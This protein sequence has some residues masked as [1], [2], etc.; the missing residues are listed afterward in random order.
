MLPFSEFASSRGSFP[1]PQVPP[2]QSGN[3]VTVNFDIAWLPF[4]LGSLQQL[5]LQSTWQ[6]D[7]DAIESTQS[8]VF[9]LISQ[10]SQ[11]SDMQPILNLRVSPTNPCELQIT[12]DNSVWLDVADISG[13]AAQAVN[14]YNTTLVNSGQTGGVYGHAPDI[15]SSPSDALRCAVATAC[16]TYLQKKVTSSLTFIKAGFELGKAASDICGDLIEAIPVFGALIKATLDMITGVDTGH[17]D[18]L[19]GWNADPDQQQNWVF[20][21]LYCRLGQDGVLT[22]E[23]FN[24]WKDDLEKELPQGGLLTLIG[25]YQGAC[26]AALGFNL[27]RSEAFIHQNDSGTACEPCSDCPD[28]WCH[29]FDFLVSDCGFVPYANGAV[30]GEGKWN[31]VH[32]EPLGAT[33]VQIQVTTPNMHI[34]RVQTVGF[35]STV[36]DL[37]DSGVT[38]WLD[39]QQL[40]P[41]YRHDGELNLD[42]NTNATGTR[43]RYDAQWAQ[44][45]A[46]SYITSIVLH[47]LGSNPFG[48]NNC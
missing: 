7:R 15:T 21:K 38:V 2:T 9:D 12:H 18:D 37:T 11:G 22:E 33:Y 10:F 4:V 34:T 1:S 48:T 14:N 19:L 30:Y 40:A 27:F 20:C 24:G 41:Y 28:T 39:D 25:Q 46:T 16:A 17:F 26:A 45:G 13:C 3:L 42:I 43:L 8:D 23:I 44:S 35:V 36:S 6:G 5:L 47:G 31:Q 29:K 32:I